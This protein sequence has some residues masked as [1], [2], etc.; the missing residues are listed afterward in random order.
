MRTLLMSF[1]LLLLAISLAAQGEKPSLEK[2]AQQKKHAERTAAVLREL[3]QFQYKAQMDI[4]AEDFLFVDDGK[5][6]SATYRAALKNGIAVKADAITTVSQVK[7]M[8][9]G[10]QIFLAD[11][12][13]ALIGSAGEKVEMSSLTV[14]QLKALAKKTLAA[15]LLQLPKPPVT[16]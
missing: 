13:C 1:I 10:I 9:F 6:L 14:E 12:A 15:M 2:L 7:I 11:D 16:S 8:E 3:T 4:P 5:L